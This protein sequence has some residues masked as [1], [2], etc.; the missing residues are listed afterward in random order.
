M[1]ISPDNTPI[2]T[3]LKNE[4][5]FFSKSLN[6]DQATKQLSF[7][8]LESFSKT[9]DFK[10]HYDKEK[11]MIGCSILVASRSQILETVSGEKIRGIGIG[12]SQILK[13]I[14]GEKFSHSNVKNY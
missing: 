9:K 8:Y 7:D 2:L 12:T 4:L 5:D 14:F 11:I 6:L 3:N 10:T 13:T 1:H